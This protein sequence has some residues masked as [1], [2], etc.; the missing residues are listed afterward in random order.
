LTSNTETSGAPS[1]SIALRSTV[2]ERVARSTEE[3]LTFLWESEPGLFGWFGTVDHK[4][5]GKRYLITA[6]AFLLVGGIEALIMRLQLAGPNQNLLDPETYNQIFTLHGTTMIYWYAAPI[7]SGFANYLIPLMLGSRDMALPRLNA[8]TYWTFLLSG[9]FLYLA[10]PLGQAPH[11]GWFAYAPYTLKRFSPGP[12]IDLFALSLLFLTISTTAGAINFLVT[13]FR[14]RAPGMS[15][16]RMPLFMYSTGTI[17]AT[18]IFSLPALSVACVFLYL[19]RNWGFHFYDPSEGGNPLLWQHLFWFFGHPWVYVIFLP[20]T[21]MVSMLLPAFSRR[22]IVGH[23]Y[24]AISTVLTGVV[25]FGVWV[26]HMF[27]VG[28]NFAAMSVFSAASMTISLFSTVQVFAWI[29]TL[30]RGR[31]VLTTSL[32]FAL[33]FIANFIIGGLNGVITAL[34]PFD[35]QV[36]DTYFVV[37]HLHYVLIGANVFPV[38]AGFYFWLPKMT[39]RLMNEQLGRVSFWLMFVG[40]NLAFFPMHHL[41]VLGMPRRI[42]T[43]P[44]GKGWDAP[45]MLASVGAFILAAGIAVSLWNF[46]YSKRRGALAGKN[47]WNAEGLEWSTESPPAVYGS[48]HIPTV[49]SRSPL[50]DAHEEEADPDGARVLDEGRFTASTT[51]VDAQPVARA[52]M[53]ED[54][55]MP[56]TAG[57]VLTVFFAAALVKSLWLAAA[58]AFATLLVAGFWLWP[59]IERKNERIADAPGLPHGD[60]FVQPIED[61]RGA[62]AMWWLIGTELALFVMLFVAYFQLGPWPNEPAPKLTLALVMLGVLL[63]SS[64]VLHWG[65]KRL[66]ANRQR[67]GRAAMALSALLGAIFLALQFFEYREHLKILTPTANTY[68]SIFYTITS[69]HALHLIVGL[70]MLMYVLVLPDLRGKR[71][72]PHRPYSTAARYWHFVD[73]IWFFIVTILYVAPNLAS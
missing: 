55:L 65:E 20:A 6:F 7:L 4:R 2:P 16:T 28:M 33:G 35:W 72:A 64:V 1:A 21:G 5:I 26:H 69:F 40:F 43:Y 60:P 12:G 37:S 10:I 52:R 30:W 56:F 27:A 31:P 63:L 14:L 48:V 23:S 44:E 53:A 54:T 15:L 34:I 3:R 32:L 29:A 49:A 42:Y 58:A 67:Q 18:I 11:A 22:P 71:W 59:E 25:G 45:N 38:F 19:E 17:S 51:A 13:I 68:G 50:W 36:H 46:F 8:F 9:L 39:G 24:V 70:L 62:L 41:G 47:P 66:E 57:L 61:R 73:V